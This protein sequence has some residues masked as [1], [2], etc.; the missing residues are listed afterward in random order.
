MT[1]FIKLLEAPKSCH[2]PIG[3]LVLGSSAQH[4]E[5]LEE[6]QHLAPPQPSGQPPIVMLM[7]SLSV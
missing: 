1:R 7:V 5:A 3:S 6:A 4:A 2:E